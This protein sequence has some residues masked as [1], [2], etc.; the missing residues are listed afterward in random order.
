MIMYSDAKRRRD[1]LAGRGLCI[2]GE[3]H[4]RA[5]DGV[6][7]PWCRDVHRRGVLVVLADPAAPPCPP[8]YRFRPRRDQR[9]VSRMT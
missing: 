7:C 6:R 5:V 8:G 1:D 2:N 9:P 4:G 3:S